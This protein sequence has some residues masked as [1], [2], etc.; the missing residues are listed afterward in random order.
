MT[1]SEYERPGKSVKPEEDVEPAMLGSHSGQKPYIAAALRAAVLEETSGFDSPPQR[2]IY[3]WRAFIKSFASKGKNTNERETVR[4]NQSGNVPMNAIPSLTVL[5]G[6][7][8]SGKSSF[9]KELKN[10]VIVNSDNIRE[11]ITGE[12]K[13]SGQEGLVWRTFSAR[14]S[15]ALKN[16][17]NIVLD[18]CHLSPRSRWHALRGVGRNYNKICIVFDIP[19]RKIRERCLEEK[20]MR[21]ETV[22]ETWNAFQKSKPSEK[23][24]K[25]E[26]FDTVYFLDNTVQCQA[27]DRKSPSKP[28]KDHNLIDDK[29][30]E[31]R[32]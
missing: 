13:L 18:A 27:E 5:C 12:Y 19:K 7:S 20:R 1:S 8:H 16:N 4:G 9:A 22:M 23:E 26:G 28:G 29:K 2:M 25:K 17:R 31:V 21:L 24:L 3:N 15:I 6:P 10:F 32:P 14:K 11:E 30:K